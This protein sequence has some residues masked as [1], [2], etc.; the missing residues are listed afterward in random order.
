[1][2]SFEYS[3]SVHFLSEPVNVLE[4]DMVCADCPLT[5]AW[6]DIL[7]SFSFDD[8]G[9]ILDDF[10]LTDEEFEEPVPSF[11]E[12]A[13][14]STQSLP[15]L[16]PEL[17]QSQNPITIITRRQD[18]KEAT[19]GTNRRLCMISGCGRID[20]GHGLCGAHGGGKRCSVELCEKASRKSGLCTLHFRRVHQKPLSKKQKL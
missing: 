5:L 14:S 8:E 9:F 11:K 2:T 19:Q 4:E 3:E 13:P 17:K 1:M 12:S 7:G 10:H 18:V 16:L 20:R 15:L 6:D